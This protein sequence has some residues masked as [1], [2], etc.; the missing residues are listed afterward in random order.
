[1]NYIEFIK[2]K[3]H[4]RIELE[5][6]LY[7][8]N[9]IFKSCYKFTDRV[10]VYIDYEYKDNKEYYIIYLQLKNESNTD[11]T[12]LFMNELLDQELRELLSNETRIIR[13][14]IVKR[15]LI[16]GQSNENNL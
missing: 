2:S 5:K 7:S 11:L 6:N 9:T 12:G 13:E 8:K 14:S 10:Y 4:I 1:M 15:A 3:N 16:S